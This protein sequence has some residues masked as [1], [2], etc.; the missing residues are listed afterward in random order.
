MTKLQNTP[1]MTIS[2][3]KE[4]ADTAA[5]AVSDIPGAPTGQ[6]RKEKGKDEPKQPKPDKKKQPSHAT[7]ERVVRGIEFTNAGKVKLNIVEIV[8]VPPK[9]PTGDSTIKH[10]KHTSTFTEQAHEDFGNSMRVMRKHCMNIYGMD[11]PEPKKLADYTV[12]GLSVNGD[13]LLKQ[14]R[15]TLTLGKRSKITSKLMKTK[16][17][18]VTLYGQ[19]EYDEA[20]KLAPMVEKALEEATAYLNGKFGGD[21]ARIKLPLFPEL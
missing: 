6:K 13:I 9:D 15:V 7:I 4:I 12:V 19:S 21:D 5:S 16:L 3:T 17:S 2:S 1:S 18:E 10:R 8:T 20:D 11:V 14:A